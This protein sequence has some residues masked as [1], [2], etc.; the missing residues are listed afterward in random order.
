M[1]LLPELAT[2]NPS[3]VTRPFWDAC[4]RRELVMQHCAACD[5][6]QHPPLAGC[7]RCGGAQ[8]AWKPVGG[9]GQVFSFTVIHHPAIPQLRE[10]VPYAAVVVELDE[11]PEARLVS[12][13]LDVSPDEIEVGM[14]VELAWDEVEGVV[15]P[16][17]RS[18]GA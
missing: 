11:A 6:Y 7:R 12:N 13:L 2:I 8:L 4:K 18:A 10:Q 5:R 9:R 16:R 1:S 3:D 17:F 14:P 15:F